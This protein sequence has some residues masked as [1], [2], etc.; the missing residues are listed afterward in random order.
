MPPCLAAFA[1]LAHRSSPAVF[2]DGTSR[3]W[4]SYY[5]RSAWPASRGFDLEFPFPKAPLSERARD[6]DRGRHLPPDE[7]VDHYLADG[8]AGHHLAGDV[9][10]HPGLGPDLVAG[11]GHQEQYV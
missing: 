7:D 3:C 4:F 11:L 5:R 1:A 8:G 2:H 9:H 6:A 10:R